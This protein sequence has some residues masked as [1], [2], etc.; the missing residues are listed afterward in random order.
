MAELIPFSPG[1]RGRGPERVVALHDDLV[2]PWMELTAIAGEYGTFAAGVMDVA[3]RIEQAMV[4]GRPGLVAMYADRLERA[5]AH[6]GGRAK[7]A[8]VLSRLRQ[9]ELEG[10]ACADAIAAPGHGAAA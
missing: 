6:Q 10:T 9:A 3:R 8:Q 4:A 2:E 5:A 7:R 1:G